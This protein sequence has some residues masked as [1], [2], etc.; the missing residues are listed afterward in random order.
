MIT[1]KS[2]IQS[3]IE[4]GKEN[5]LTSHDL[6]FKNVIE[7]STGNKF[8]VNMSSIFDKYYDILLQHAVVAI[9]SE[10]DY[11]KYRY[12]PKVLSKD[13]YGT[14]DL[15]FLL[16]RLNNITSV[17]QFDFKE[18]KVFTNDIVRL[19]NEII[20]LEYENYTDNEIDVIKKM[21]E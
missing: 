3:I 1:N 13:I 4:E 17:T 5:R 21:N 10:D 6:S 20:I 9:L 7:D 16:L 11:L 19:L 8:V 18:V 2:T 12:K 15:H 14:R